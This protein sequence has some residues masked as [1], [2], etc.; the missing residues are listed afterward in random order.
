MQ[1]RAIVRNSTLLFAAFAAVVASCG[2]QARRDL[3][4]TAWSPAEPV[5][6]SAPIEVRFDRPVVDAGEVGGAVDPDAIAVSPAVAW[7]GH[8]QD[9]QTI[10]L[11]VGE[12]LQPGTRYTVRLAG[13]LARRAGPFAFSFV[14]R[15]LVLDGLVGADPRA[16]SPGG[17]LAVTFNQPVDPADVA[18][19]CALRGDAGTVALVA[20]PPAAP[21]PTIRVQAV[22]PL[23]RGATYRLGCAGLTAP[24][25]D[26]ALGADAGLDVTV[27]PHLTVTRVGPIGW[28][29]PA[30]EVAIEIEL[31]APVG[32]DAI[33]A[34]VTSRPPIPGLGTGYLD[35]DGRVY[36][37]V[38]DLETET[39]YE[40]RITDLADPHG[41]RADDHV[42][43][44]TTGDARP[45]ISMQRGMVAVEASA[46]GLPVWSRNIPSYDVDCAAIPKDK[47]IALV[48]GDRAF[49]AWGGGYDDTPVPWAEL[50]VTR[51]RT[52]VE[53]AGAKNKWHLGHL[54]L[55][56]TCGGSRAG[57]GVYLAEVSSAAIAAD[58]GRSWWESRSH[59]VV[60]NVTD[61]GILLKIGT[62]SGIAWVTSLA[63]GEPV[64]GAKV[65]L[66]TPAGKQVWVARTDRDGLIQTPGAAKLLSLPARAD[67]VADDACF[68]C[69]GWDSYRSHRLIAVV[70]HGDDLAIVDGNWADGIQIWSFGV[71]EDRS[72]GAT[73]IRGFIQSDRG[74][75]RPGETVHFKGIVREI[76]LANGPRVPTRRPVEIEVSDSR[77]ATAWTGDAPLS[78]FGGFSFDL[79]LAAEAALGDWYV[80]ATVDGQVFRERFS[81][82]EFRPASFE[83]ALTSR[84]TRA[85]IGERVDVALGATY[86]FGAP[87]ADA[88]VAWTVSRRRHVLQFAGFDGYTF[89]DNAD[90]GWWGDHP[91]DDPG[92]FVSDGE[93]VTDA[94]GRH[95]LTIRDPDP[96]VTAP[97]DYVIHAAV[98]DQA[99]QTI[100]AS[101]VIT[102]HRADVYLGL[103]TREWVHVAGRPFAVDLVAVAPDGKQVA[104]DVKLTVIHEVGDCAWIELAG[105]SYP[106]CTRRDDVAIER[107][108]AIPASGAATERISAKAPGDYRIVVE[109]K[110]SRGNRVV[111]STMAWVV[112]KGAA[113]WGGDDSARMTLIASKRS[114][115]P[116]ETARLVAQANLDA[117]TALITIERDGVIR[118]EVRKLASAAE[119]V[120]LAIDDAWA[121]NVFA[122][123]ALVSGRTGDGD[124][125]RPR[126]KLGVVELEV[127]SG[128][129][130][131]DVQVVLDDAKVRPGAPVR[132][133]VVV[134]RAGKPVDAELSLSVA[135]E[136]VLQLIAYQTPDPM[137]TFYATWGLG[138]DAST[139][140]TRIARLTDPGAT[141]PDEG[142]DMAA[143]AGPRIRSRFVTSAFW[144]PALVTGADGVAEFTFTAP[145]NLTAFRVMA[146]AADARDRFGAGDVRL[147]VDKPLM[148][149]P[150]LPRFVGAGD[151]LSVGVVVHNHTDRA[152][153]AKLTIAADGLTI[154]TTT[155]EIAV[156]AGGSA[157]VR[158]AAIASHG[159]AATIELTATMNGE[160]D[161]L[162]V[163]VPIRRA[164]IVDVTAAGADPGT[165]EVRTLTL[166]IATNALRAESELVISVDRTGLGD[167]EPSLRYLV[168]YPYGCLEQTL[169]RFVPLAKAKDLSRSLGFAQLAGTKMDAYVAAGVTKVARHQ[170]GDGHFGLWPDA[171]PHPHLT[172]YALWGLTEARKAGAR[173]PEDTLTRGADA[174]ARWLADRSTIGPGNQGATAAMAAW[175]LAD[176]GRADAGSVQRLY[177]LRAALPRW[178][179]AFLLRAMI[180]QGAAASMIDTVE[181]ELVA[182]IDVTDGVARVADDGTDDDYYMTSGTRATAIVLAALVERDPA[183]AMIPPLI[184]GLDALRRA[185]GRWGNTQDNL[186]SLLALADY[187][188]HATP[189]TGSVT[190]TAG[191]QQ[192]AVKQVSGSQ[193]AVVRQPLDALGDDTVTIRADPGVHWKARLVQATVDD[194]GAVSAGFSVK[195]EYLDARDRPVTRIAAGELVTV[196]L[197]V[198]ADHD[199]AWVAL[200][201][202][203]PAGVEAVNP[204]LVTSGSTAA[205]ATTASWD[206]DPPTWVHTEQR[207]DRVLW[208][209]DA[210]PRGTHVMTYQARATIDGTFAVLPA[211]VEA[212]YEPELRG[213][214]ASS[215]VVVTR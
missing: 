19:H 147:T 205:T 75:Y 77:G 152:G 135:D 23:A 82:E 31:S 74:L 130:R 85:R 109:T 71:P 3:M 29:I 203:L 10:V 119:G 214:T 183:H 30:D 162:R 126:F 9:R 113:W 1:L 133:K 62:A 117:P 158:F 47:L 48:S 64:A 87:V 116:G 92:A 179:Q 201:D 11:E 54:D 213:R 102:A 37:V 68:E 6:D 190:I 185:D 141:D 200:V 21:A 44:F 38:A 50:G 125:H 91:G 49:D 104:T 115:Q 210:L 163:T 72:G 32:L 34:A 20:L 157:R 197:T 24:G 114:Y 208:F 202:P 14:H 122:S 120:E 154:A 146:V 128:H 13:P 206:W 84:D 25:G 129:K 67:A 189:G 215:T 26:A 180:A 45:R 174:L 89:E 105:R 40:L 61:L 112:G 192:V 165:G 27:R 15:P 169:S 88:K 103:H 121:P 168:E 93:G 4:V 111:A 5:D 155:Q 139:N 107:T 148:A 171:E 39:D 193:V 95:T 8:W 211:T 143:D 90:R 101:R 36:R 41:D 137:N 60:V 167:L 118:A 199:R 194:G 172:V 100:A 204:R 161:G 123:V 66:Y 46:R 97:H 188:R 83:V 53:I 186:W 159:R 94:R 16:I 184:A 56:Q 51:K 63:T 150:V 22:A 182:A 207:D 140:R 138:V 106:R 55:G 144:A 142:G 76:S 80:T 153:T 178:G 33:R 166:P 65:V 81:V 2:A 58:P 145:D 59:R 12:P 136:G 35:A 108:V 195:R 156:A 149:T 99:D 181:R 73:R 127:D 160:Q 164:R 86:L 57:R 69:D 198:V 96:A 110:D 151:R 212:M 18:R 134:T 52:Q 131:L 7:T 17:A 132:G 170:H 124:R 177:Q 70:D 78:R 191:G 196:R 175:V 173:V 43:E 79:P 209:S 98:T 42:H 28:Q 176:N 187:A